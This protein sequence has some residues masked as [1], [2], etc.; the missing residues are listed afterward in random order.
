MMLTELL[1]F[2][3][4]PSR[5]TVTV[6]SPSAPLGPVGPT[7][8]RSTPDGP[9]GV[10]GPPGT[11][12]AGEAKPSHATATSAPRTRPLASHRNDVAM[13]PPGPRRRPGATSPPRGSHRRVRR[14][15]LLEVPF[16]PRAPRVRPGVALPCP[17]AP[18]APP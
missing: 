11:A 12:S 6:L 18:H 16:G 3:V 13:K 17:P 1:G 7:G 8:S 5:F 10:I 4:R 9:T 2:S 15:S 14:P